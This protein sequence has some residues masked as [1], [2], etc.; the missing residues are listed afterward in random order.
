LTLPQGPA[1]SILTMF[2]RRRR[3]NS[4]P[5]ACE[6]RR[7]KAQAFVASSLKS[8]VATKDRSAIAGDL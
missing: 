7:R 6:S 5:P 4:A 3:P 1:A 8:C 2:V